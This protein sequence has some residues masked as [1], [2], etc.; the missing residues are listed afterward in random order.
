MQVY[1]GYSCIHTADQLLGWLDVDATHPEGISVF[2]RVFG[3]SYI[4]PGDFEVY[5]LEDMDNG[6]TAAE[7]KTCFPFP[8]E[9]LSLWK[10]DLEAAT[11][12]FWIKNESEWQAMA[13][14]GIAITDKLE[15]AKFSYEA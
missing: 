15:V 12:V 5:G 9:E 8:A 10:A 14:E 4:G 13:A 7:L 11:C 3:C 1:V 6:F 2:E